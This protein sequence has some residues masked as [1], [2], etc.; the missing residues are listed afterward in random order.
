MGRV[1]ADNGLDRY[2]A[3]GDG[4]GVNGCDRIAANGASGRSDGVSGE[5]GD[6]S[7]IA[8][9][10]VGE[11][12]GNM[13]GSAPSPLASVLLDLLLLLRPSD[14]AGARRCQYRTNWLQT[15]ALSSFVERQFKHRSATPSNALIR[16]ANFFLFFL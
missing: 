14:F 16:I 5:G 11:V 8:T 3:I 10:G 15:V 6:K 1:L 9:G 12:E 13:G 4:G 7:G 2:D